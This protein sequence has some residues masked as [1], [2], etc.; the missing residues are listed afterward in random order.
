MAGLSRR[1]QKWFCGLTL[2]PPYDGSNRQA[3]ASARGRVSCAADGQCEQSFRRAGGL[4]RSASTQRSGGRSDSPIALGPL[5]GPRIRHSE[6]LLGMR[7]AV[8]TVTG[9]ATNM[10]A[11]LT[12]PREAGSA[13]TVCWCGARSALSQSTETQVW[14]RGA[15]RVLITRRPRC[16]KKAGGPSILTEDSN[17]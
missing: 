8:V 6:S 3:L 5:L 16:V 17:S 7:F 13:G 9:P 10:A 14:E 12:A 4:A 11:P 1:K 15:A 2:D